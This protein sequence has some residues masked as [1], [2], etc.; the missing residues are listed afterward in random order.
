METPKG[1][2][3]NE[4]FGGKFQKNE[5]ERSANSNNAAPNASFQAYTAKNDL[6]VG[7][8]TSAEAHAFEYKSGRDK[9]VS[10]DDVQ[11][12]VKVAGVKAGLEGEIGK[13]GVS[14][15]VTA[16]ARLVEV[17]SDL[18]GGKLALG[19]STGGSIG[20][21]GGEVKLA[22]CGVAV[23]LNKVGV[24]LFDTEIYISPANILERLK[25]KFW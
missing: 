18:A 21:G 11:V 2:V 1:Q 13:A 15:G 4:E 19:L 25:L 14:V 12:E 3:L 6:A 24:S 20:L 8:G 5:F 16:E 7:A 10:K 9:T 23:G 22:G 17:K